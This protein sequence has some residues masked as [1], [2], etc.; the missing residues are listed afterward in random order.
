LSNCANCCRRAGASP[1]RSAGELDRSRVRAPRR[2][3]RR[4]QSGGFIREGHGDL[5]LGNLVLIDGRVTPFDCIEFNEDFRWNDPASEIAFVWIDLLDH[6]RPAWP[7][8]S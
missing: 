7:H 1:G 2:R 4:T 6:G 8:G 5:H 3:F